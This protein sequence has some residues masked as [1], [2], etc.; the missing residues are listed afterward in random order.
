[1]I[2]RP[3]LNLMKVYNTR[4]RWEAREIL[5]R[6]TTVAEDRKSGVLAVV[7]W[8]RD[9]KRAAAIAR[10]YIEELNTIAAQLNTSSAG[11]ERE[12]IEKRLQTAKQE[13][14]EAAVRL[15]EFSG[16]NSTVDIK[17][18]AHAM[19]SGFATL[20]GE[21]IAAE[22]E[23]NGLRQIF[24]DDNARVRSLRAR[25]AE[26]QRQLE[27]MGGVP[28]AA[29]SAAQLFPSI[30]QLPALGVQYAELY[31]RAKVTEVVYDLLT[32]QY[33]LARIQEAK[34]LPSVRVLDEPDVPEKKARPHRSIIVLVSVF[35]ALGLAVTW[36]FVRDR[37]EHMNSVDPR[38]LVV[39]A[40]WRAVLD[41]GNGLKRKTVKT[42]VP[43]A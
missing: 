20:Q 8:D 18:Q 15:A 27:K 26:L 39:V 28:G 30:R 14:D 32:Q 29:P 42:A 16:K 21:L 10:G 37:W 22:S 43:R 2:D 3:D 13:L 6:R 31:R 38:K 40:S 17:E 25:V 7:V 33:E 23:L 19:V 4:Q 34:E 11:R 36:V 5:Q 35:A 1:L 12:F 9:P 24:T 41:I